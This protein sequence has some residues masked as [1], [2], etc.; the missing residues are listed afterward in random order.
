M[1]FLVGAVTLFFVVGVRPA[2]PLVI[3]LW[4][5]LVYGF[6]SPAPEPELANELEAAKEPPRI[7]RHTGLIAFT[8][9]NPI[10][11][12]YQLPAWLDATQS[13]PV[14]DGQFVI[15]CDVGTTK[16]RHREPETDEYCFKQGD[17]IYLTWSYRAG[18]WDVAGFNDE[19]TWHEGVAPTAALQNLRVELTTDATLLERLENA[20]CEKSNVWGEA[21]RTAAI[22]QA[23]ILVECGASRAEAQWRE[24][25]DAG[26]TLAQYQLG[27]AYSGQSTDSAAEKNLD[28]ALPVLEQAAARGFKPALYFLGML[29][30]EGG[31]PMQAAAYFRDAVGPDTARATFNLARAHHLGDGVPQDLGEAE[32]LYRLAAASDDKVVEEHVSLVLRSW[33]YAP[34]EVLWLERAEAG[35]VKAQVRLAYAYSS[36]EGAPRDAGAAVRWNR[37][38]AQGGHGLAANN[39]ACLYEA[40]DGVARDQAEANRWFEI[41]VERESRPGQY[42]LSLNL[43]DG[44]NVPRDV[45]RAIALLKAASDGGYAKAAYKLAQLYRTG[46]IEGVEKDEYN[47]REFDLVAYRLGHPMSILEVGHSYETGKDG[48]YDPATAR[49]YYKRAAKSGDPDVLKRLEELGYNE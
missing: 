47:A 25:A 48:R 8:D 45:E 31:D 35:D 37:E 6:A 46:E 28:I 20:Y 12:P 14:S 19:G 5:A 44:K 22:I 2:L 36:G 16:E 30:V 7:D 17:T 15:V 29:A 18:L 27:L 38:A 9:V 4:F 1:I 26:E 49:L 34:E 43:L 24:R 11:E 23:A 10:T 3:G 32:H 21:E 33:G 42:N 39:L 40:G 41:A 13:D